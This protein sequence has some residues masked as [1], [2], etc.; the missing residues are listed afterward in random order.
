MDAY[1]KTIMPFCM[2]N[3]QRFAVAGQ[4]PPRK[5]HA[6]RLLVSVFPNMD[7]RQLPSKHSSVRLA[8]RS[9]LASSWLRTAPMTLAS[10]IWS[11]RVPFSTRTGLNVMLTNNAPNAGPECISNVYTML[12]P[13]IAFRRRPFTRNPTSRKTS[14]RGCS[15]AMPTLAIG[16]GSF[17]CA[18]VCP[19]KH[20][21]IFIAEALRFC[22]GAAGSCACG[23]SAPPT[24]T[25]TPD[26]SVIWN[27]LPEFVFVRF[28][29]RTR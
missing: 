12:S 1:L 5:R 28:Q 27:T 23:W 20:A 26:G 24:E 3:Q 22:A 11:W 15:A 6:G 17:L 9:A 18:W 21:S 7:Q 29:T 13:R 10:I 25:A 19:Y 8:R 16:M 2:A 4:P 14:S